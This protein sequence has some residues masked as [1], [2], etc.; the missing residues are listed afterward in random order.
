M[1]YVSDVAHYFTRSF[2][3]RRCHPQEEV[4]LP[5]NGVQASF[6]VLVTV[7]GLWDVT[8]CCWVNDS[9]R[10]GDTAFIGNVNNR[11]LNDTASIP[12]RRNVKIYV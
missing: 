11:S 6:D 1:L 4:L 8:K 9:G 5:I 7:Q 2:D 10:F 3:P 12:R